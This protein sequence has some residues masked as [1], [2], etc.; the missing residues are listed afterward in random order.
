[1]AFN[2]EFKNL[3]NIHVV[4]LQNELQKSAENS[5][6]GQAT[7]PSTNLFKNPQLDLTKE[8]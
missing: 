3:P 4:A 2:K 6:H 1:M 8:A 7:R 5:S